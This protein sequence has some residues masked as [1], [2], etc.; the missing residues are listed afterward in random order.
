[1]HAVETLEMLSGQGP[2]VDGSSSSRQ[3]VIGKHAVEILEMSSGRG[4]DVGGS[5]SSRQGDGWSMLLKH[6]NVIMVRA[7]CILL[8]HSRCR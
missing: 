8:R 2:G 4:P 1:M 6:R 5:V 3:G 7:R